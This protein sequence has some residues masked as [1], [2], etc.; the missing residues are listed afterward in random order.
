MLIR[1]INQLMQVEFEAITMKN[2]LPQLAALCFYHL[3]QVS[4]DL[5]HPVS[6]RGAGDGQSFVNQPLRHAVRA[7]ESY[8][9][10][11]IVSAFVCW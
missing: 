9:H 6:H 2:G 10:V 4:P 5:S 3:I 11:L 1:N 8:Q 7:H